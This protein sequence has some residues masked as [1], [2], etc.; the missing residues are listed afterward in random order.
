MGAFGAI[1]AWPGVLR[2]LTAGHDLEP[3]VTRAALERILAG[4]ATDAQIAAFIVALRQKG[5]T[6]DEVVG[7]VAA[8]LDVAAPLLLDDP[9]ATI[10]IVGTG[11]STALAGKA[12]NVSTMASIVAAGAGAVVC[13]HGNRRASSTSGSTDLLE[14]LGVEVELDGDGVAACVREAGV[15]FAFARMFHPSM[16]HVAPVRAE[17]GI[18]TVFNVLGPLSHPARVGRQVIGVADPRLMELV[19][20]V[21]RR[22]GL[23]RAW[24]VHGEGGLDELTTAGSSRVVEL[25]EGELRHFEVVPEDVGLPRATL[26]ELG[27]GGPEEN[28]RTAEAVIAGTS[29]PL[30]DMVVLNAAAGLVVAGVVD[31]LSSGVEAAAASID[32]GRAA[33]VLGRLVAA[34]R[35]VIASHG[36]GSG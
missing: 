15:G 17:L 25:R 9:D 10:D 11:G 32:D 27:V 16:R 20:D 35:A 6:P 18:P 33:R 34:S 21:L 3:N 4:E 7:L 31:D 36:D 13:K 19:P 2:E 30:R 22:R 5:E 14:A 29:G 8:M 12:F 23:S 1:G 28:A 26:A 24:I